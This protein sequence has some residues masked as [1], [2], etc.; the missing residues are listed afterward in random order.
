VLATLVRWGETKP[1]V[2]E[3]A[4][5]NVLTTTSRFLPRH[6]GGLGEVGVAVSFSDK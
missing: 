6:P 1:S 2:L 3:E 4:E 5:P